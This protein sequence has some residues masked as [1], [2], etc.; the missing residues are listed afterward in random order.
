MQDCNF[1][2]CSYS[3]Q[4]DEVTFGIYKFKNLLNEQSATATVLGYNAKAE[5]LDAWISNYG[6]DEKYSNVGFKIKLKREYVRHVINYYMPSGIFVLVSWISFLIPPDVIPGRM[7]LLITVLLVLINLFNSIKVPP[8]T[9]P[10]ALDVWML[11]CVFFVTLALVAY[12][13]LLYLK[14]SPTKQPSMKIID[15]KSIIET[16]NPGSPSKTQI[17]GQEHLNEKL[18]HLDRIFLVIFP[19][20]FILFNL[21]YWLCTHATN[22]NAYY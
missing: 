3:H 20:L 21:I 19:L 22:H 12:A 2:L 9:S 17:V 18:A 16:R 10:N 13:F 11:S 6:E 5:K 1:E 8:A 15:V 14:L 7:G 4:S